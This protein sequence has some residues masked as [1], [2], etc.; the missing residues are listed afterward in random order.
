M[1]VLGDIDFRAVIDNDEGIII[2]NLREKSITAVGYDLT[3]GFICD[4][5]DGV[6]PQIVASEN[7]P[8]VNQYC[9][10]RG[11]RYL[12]ISRE[13][14]S[15][16]TQYM[17]TLHSRASYMLKGILITSTTIDPNF[18]GF[19]YSSLIN[20]S[21]KD[22]YIKENN[23]YVTMVIH[24]ILTPT[25]TILQTNENGTP[26]DG[27]ETLNTPFS[28]IDPNAAMYA[29]MYIADE[30]QKIKVS[31]REA[32][33]KAAQ[34]IQEKLDLAT[35]TKQLSEKDVLNKQSLKNLQ[36]QM[37][38]VQAELIKS[39]QMVEREKKKQYRSTI[40]LCIVVSVLLFLL[41]CS[42][43]GA[44]LLTIL[45]SIIVPIVLS[46]PSFIVDFKEVLDI[47]KNFFQKK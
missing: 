46:I 1:S 44:S 47:I 30:F 13:Y 16:P 40:I 23:Q 19:I 25:N 31:H 22:V 32:Q 39:K 11:H 20:C 14:I 2:S 28:N 18:E 8:S 34:R 7:D 35:H 43:F 42:Y 21:Q 9:L 4:A 3:I 37:D 5:D 15:F 45:I 6:I 12:I 10:L 24:Q 17:A 36:D 33:L 29:K 38:S 26:K 41:L 27:Q